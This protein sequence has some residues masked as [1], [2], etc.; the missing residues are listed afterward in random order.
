[1]SLRW[2]QG[3]VKNVQIQR[4]GGGGRKTLSQF[5]F[6]LTSYLKFIQEGRQRN[7]TAAKITR[8]K[9]F[10]AG[11][12]VLW[13]SCSLSPPL[14]LPPPQ[15]AAVLPPERLSCRWCLSNNNR[16]HSR[17]KGNLS[18]MCGSCEA[19]VRRDPGP[20]DEPRAGLAWLS[21][22]SLLRPHHWHS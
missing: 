12:S 13:F 1:M 18:V 10:L 17:A 11:A 20:E 5:S 6:S 4:F 7:T 2:G 19:S 22:D 21:Q 15:L 3:E 9:S 8:W 16:C 14:L